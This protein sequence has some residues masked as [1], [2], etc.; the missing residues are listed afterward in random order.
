MYS[1]EKYDT[2]Y[3]ALLVLKVGGGW[4]VRLKDNIVF[5]PDADHKHK[6]EPLKNQ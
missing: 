3:G 6:P 1:W 4:L 2:N 5:V